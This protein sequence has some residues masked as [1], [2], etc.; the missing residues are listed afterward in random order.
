MDEAEAIRENLKTL[1]DK[2]E[3]Q[4]QELGAAAHSKDAPSVPEPGDPEGEAR[5]EM[6]SAVQRRA[7]EEEQLR[8]LEQQLQKAFGDRK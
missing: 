4:L 8:D 6:E 5:E 7:R 1:R 2:T 3:Q